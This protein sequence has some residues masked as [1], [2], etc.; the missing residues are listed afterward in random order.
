[1]HYEE[2]APS[3]AFAALIS[4]LWA[5]ETTAEDPPQ[6]DHVVMPDGACNLTLIEPGPQGQ[7]YVSLSGPS[8]V[9]LR[10]PIFRGVRYRG[11]RIQPGALRAFLG[12][13]VAK[14]VG[15]N[16]PLDSVLPECNAAL[17]ASMSQLP[18]ALATFASGIEQQFADRVNRAD[19]LDEAVQQVV[20]L[21]VKSEGTESLSSLLASSGLSERQLRRRFVAEVGITPKL[22]SRLRRVRRACIDLLQHKRLGVAAIASE[23]GFADQAHFSHELRAIFGLSPQLLHQYLSQ[24]QHTNVAGLNSDN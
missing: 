23:H 10:V 20:A 19:R 17:C 4:R 21:L 5:F 22:F 1:M 15:K 3:P 12:I 6:I 9:A 18:E 7:L 14:I 8:A 11:M 2:Q 16:L 24:I 13:N